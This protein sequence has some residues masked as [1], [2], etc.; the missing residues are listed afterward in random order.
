MFLKEDL[1]E[2]RKADFSFISHKFLE[3]KENGNRSF[4]KKNYLE[5]LNSYIEV[6]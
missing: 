6:T 5:A 3:L 4:K 2:I 1:E